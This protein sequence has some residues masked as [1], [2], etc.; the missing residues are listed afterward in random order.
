VPEFELERAASSP[1]IVQYV[2]MTMVAAASAAPSFKTHARQEF[3]ARLAYGG[4]IRSF[5]FS[6][7][8]QND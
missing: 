3:P 4:F 2:K 5:F 6:T 1:E 8:N 7:I